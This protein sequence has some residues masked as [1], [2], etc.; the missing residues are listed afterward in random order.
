M[1]HLEYII[2]E[3]HLVEKRIPPDR[4]TVPLSE[5]GQR[6]GSFVRIYS[7]PNGFGQRNRPSVRYHPFKLEMVLRALAEMNYGDIEIRPMPCEM[8][9]TDIDKIDWYRLIAQK[10]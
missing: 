1:F 4:G 7:V 6:D 2:P 3:T 8:P 5:F 10:Q 9:E